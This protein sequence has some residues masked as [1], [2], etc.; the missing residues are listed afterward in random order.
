M[1][2]RSSDGDGGI[3]V[4]EG[5]NFGLEV[6]FSRGGVPPPRLEL[7]ENLTDVQIRTGLEK[8]A[9]VKQVAEDINVHK[10]RNDLR[11]EWTMDDKLSL[12]DNVAMVNRNLS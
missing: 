3:A 6:L 10:I 5:Q 7:R 9:C 8:V 12:C 4:D 11:R 1:S 2:R